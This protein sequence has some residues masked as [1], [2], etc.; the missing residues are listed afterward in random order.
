MTP[1]MQHILTQRNTIANL[2]LQPTR[3]TYEEAI[4]QHPQVHGSQSV[5]Q[6]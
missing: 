4:S 3:N 1:K 6:A 5:A 2:S